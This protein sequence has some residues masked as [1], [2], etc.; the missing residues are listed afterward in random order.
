[1]R[2]GSGLTACCAARDSSCSRARS[3]RGPLLPDRQQQADDVAHHVVQERIG[4]HV[5][6]DPVA[7]SARRCSARSCAH[8]RARLALGG[9]KGT[10]IVLADQPLRAPACIA[11][12]SSG[13]CTSSARPSA[14]AE[15]VTRLRIR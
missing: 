9:A 1:M 7:A 11:A 6:G 13:W 5:D 14:S 8:R 2:R 3:G 4:G 15:R 12:T 10:E